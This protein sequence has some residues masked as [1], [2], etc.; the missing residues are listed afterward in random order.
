MKTSSLWL[1]RNA[2]G[3]ERFDLLLLNI[4]EVYAGLASHGGTEVLCSE[5]ERIRMH[6]VYRPSYKLGI[7]TSEL[8]KDEYLSVVAE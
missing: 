3:P 4:R 7:G 8:T 1:G 5:G 6:C 2:V